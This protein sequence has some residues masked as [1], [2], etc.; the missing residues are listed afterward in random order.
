M[1]FKF[2][3]NDPVKPFHKHWQFCIGSDHAA[4]A[5]RADYLKQLKFIHD[6]LGIQYVRFHGIL[7]D[8][9]HTLDN[10]NLILAGLPKGEKIVERNFYLCGV[11][12]DNILSIGMKPFVELS[13]MPQSL[14]K[15][16]T[17]NKGFYGSNFNNPRNLQ[18]WADYIKDFVKYLIHR[19]GNEEAE[20]WYFE[21]WNEP[22]LEGAFYL[23]SKEEYFEL[24]EV[25][26][27]AIKEI[28][29]MLKVGGP[30]TSGSRWVNDFIAF[31][32]NSKLPLDFVSTH[33]YAG[34]P[35]T[36]VEDSENSNIVK[37]INKEEKVDK[38]EKL[39]K[40]MEQLNSALPENVTCLEVLKIMFG[41]PSETKDLTSDRFKRNAQTVKLQASEYPIF[42][43]E[44]NML[45][46]FSA[47][48]NDTRKAAAY[49]MKAALD[50]EDYVT[51]T[52]VWCFSD[53]FEE[54]H[55]FKEEFHGGFGLQTIHGIPKPTYYA[56]KL[57]SEV[58]NERYILETDIT[59]QEI[60]VAAFK[61]EREVDI[62]L[63]RQ[64]MKQIDLPKEPV[65]LV[66]ELQSIPS[67]VKLQRIDEDHCNPLK[68]WESNGSKPD[69]TAK[70]V[71]EIK[72]LS[73]LIEEDL[74][75]KYEDG[76]LTCNVEMA[77]NDIYHIKIKQD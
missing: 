36:G 52:S 5:L 24:Y 73:C 32:N 46:T 2:N 58:G 75:Y 48:S 59:D 45:A 22:D 17:E 68:I 65:N 56:F 19:Y 60:G 76:K 47:Y 31:C 54:M 39:V 35:L 41:D 53:I 23:G 50:V 1:D 9:M 74:D 49:D 63:F 14:A 4:Q 62:L 30:A 18:E 34:D 57:L 42:Y 38:A 13:F 70:E 21:V 7:N 33:Q 67:C 8:D 27:T 12:Y 26:A 20:S 72:K 15:N 69:L 3:I 71:E 77:V 25:T 40:Q 10:F 11:A 16:R 44:W 37:N 6:E 61:T 28:N 51:G 29:P 55:Q 43:T 64:N 66:L